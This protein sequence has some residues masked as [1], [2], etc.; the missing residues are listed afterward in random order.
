MKAYKVFDKNWM[1]RY[2][3]YAVGETYE[4]N[5]RISICNSGFH[6][7]LKLSDC[8]NY[9]SF[10]SNNKVAEVEILGDYQTSNSDSKICTNKIKIIKEL[11]W[12][13]VLIL[14]N[15]G[16]YNSGHRNPGNY[17]SG[18]RNSGHRNS[19]DRN[20][21]H[22]NSGDSNSGHRN[23]GHR[24]PGNYNS[25]H[26]NPGNYNS[27]LSNSG[28][29]NSG[30][31]NSGNYNSGNYNSGD[32]NSGNYNSGNYNSGNYNSGDRN[33]GNYNS[34]NYNSGLFNTKKP[35]KLIYCFNKLITNEQYK[36]IKDSTGY[37][38]INSFK[39]IKY[40]IRTQTGKF[41]DY[42]YCSYKQSW[43]IF[44]NKLDVKK[45]LKVKRIPFMNKKIFYKITGIKL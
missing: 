15:S 42:E 5:E 9:Y 44:W 35:P 11:S 25:G 21:G 37:E 18:D 20:S 41:G 27:G 8:F 16:N 4:T 39:L 30:D 45:K 14:C 19:G 29:R 22:Y 28:H 12:S 13:E 36:S 40:R 23:S 26:R 34:G 10:N 1:C 3:Q 2:F 31:S 38:I 32:R 24:N 6:A 17:N 7:C 43:K 33:S